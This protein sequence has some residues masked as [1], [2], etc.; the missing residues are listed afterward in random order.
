MEAIPARIRIVLYER[1]L[2]RQLSRIFQGFS[3]IFNR[4]SHIKNDIFS[5]A[6]YANG[7][8]RVI[9]SRDL[10]TFGG[11][12]FHWPSRIATQPGLGPAF[13]GRPAVTYSQIE[14]HQIRVY[15]KNTVSHPYFFVLRGF[16]CKTSTLRQRSNG[17]SV[18]ITSDFPP[19]AGRQ[20]CTFSE[21]NARAGFS[22]TCNLGKSSA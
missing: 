8:T 12:R 19:P 11:K 18:F 21:E 14:N 2:H 6:P 9:F 10:F 5:P 1:R 16:K 15:T 22:G 4:N 17:W 7:P 3:Q 20:V 13:T